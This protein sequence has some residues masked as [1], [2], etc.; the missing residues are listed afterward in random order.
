MQNTKTSLNPFII[1]IGWIIL[2]ITLTVILMLFSIIG[3]SGG[4]QKPLTTLST[5]I[6]TTFYSL[7][8]ISI[9][10]LF[11]YRSW[12]KRNWWFSF[13]IL[14]SLIPVTRLYFYKAK[15]VRYSFSEINTQIGGKEI[16]T[17][18]EYYDNFKTIRSISIWKNNKRDSVW[19]VFSKDGRI[20]DQQTF[21]NDTLIGK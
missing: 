1:F 8:A 4:E 16:K 20:V 12:F 10:T 6:S 2:M 13:I 5:M 18:I 9:V 14:L 15:D 19:K 7:A 3:S 17:K 11:I 21:K